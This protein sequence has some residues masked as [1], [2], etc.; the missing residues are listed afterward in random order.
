[1]NN[2]I[3]VVDDDE[4]YHLT[5]AKMIE[6][7]KIECKVQYF[8]DGQEAIDF[9]YSEI[10]DVDKLPDVIMLDINMPNMDGW[11]FMEEYALK[12]KPK[13]PKPI[14]VYMVSSSINQKDIDRA[15]K[16]SD[17]SS[18]LVKPITEPQL[19]QILKLLN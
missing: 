11:E 19:R 17:V 12:L 6:F 2:S 5:I 7:S 4:I 14:T 1:M 16:I 18:Y 15:N 9:L 8:F 10:N 3:A 13:L